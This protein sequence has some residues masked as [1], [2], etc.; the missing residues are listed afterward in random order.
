MEKINK[1]W[2]GSLQTLSLLFMALINVPI[3][4]HLSNTTTINFLQDPPYTDQF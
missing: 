1:Y 4:N 3:M 2:K